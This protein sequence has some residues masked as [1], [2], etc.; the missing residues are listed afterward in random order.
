MCGYIWSTGPYHLIAKSKRT[1]CPKCSNKVRRTHDDFVAEVAK[2]SPT[3]KILGT[4][5]GVSKPILVQC[6][7]CGK[8]WQAYAGNLLRGGSCK[9]CSLKKAVR[10]RS[11]KVRCIS[12]GEIFHTLREAAGKYNIS[13]SSICQCCSNRNKTAGGKEWEYID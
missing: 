9:S 3:I 12:T 10:Q 8:I 1:G 2:S 6:D 5:S 11:R 4:F 7:E 13:S